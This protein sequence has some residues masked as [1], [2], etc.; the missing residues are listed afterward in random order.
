MSELKRQIARI[1]AERS[2]QVIINETTKILNA[3]FERRIKDMELY[4]RILYS[5]LLSSYSRS[6]TFA[7]NVGIVLPE[8]ETI[9]KALY[10]MSKTRQSKQGSFDVSKAF[11]IANSLTLSYKVPMVI[12]SNTLT[13]KL[14]FKI[15]HPI[16]IALEEGNMSWEGMEN[17]KIIKILGAALSNLDVKK[18]EG[19]IGAKTRRPIER[20]ILRAMKQLKDGNFKIIKNKRP[21]MEIAI[22]NLV[23]QKDFIN[24]LIK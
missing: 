11:Q 24:I 17:S 9:T 7:S 22:K 10:A 8:L 20:E 4:S 2:R 23:K 3:K 18:V 12:E 13:Y 6:N 14:T 16:L 21:Y 1:I 5:S 19:K 15:N